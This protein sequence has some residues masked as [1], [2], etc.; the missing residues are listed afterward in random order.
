MDVSSAT[1][2]CEQERADCS[3]KRAQ[4]VMSPDTSQASSRSIT[5]SRPEPF[6]LASWESFDYRAWTEELMRHQVRVGIVVVMVL[7]GVVAP[8]LARQMGGTSEGVAA[9]DQIWLKAVKAGDVDGLVALY[10]PEAVLYTP[11]AMELR[12]TAA[13]RQHYVD[14]MKMI[15]VKDMKITSSQ[16]HTAGDISVGWFRWTMVAVPTDS[17]DP[18]TIEGRATAIARKID[19]KWLYINDHAS[20][21]APAPPQAPAPKPRSSAN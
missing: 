20:I 10:A 14:M 19:G 15:A 18:I 4:L 16:Y 17:P 3:K 1:G 8:T 6:R 12:G 7:T 5:R 11:D 9:L 13:I 21:P 2:R